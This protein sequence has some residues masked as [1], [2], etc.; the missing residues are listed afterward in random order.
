MSS[1][2]FFFFH[3]FV[4][5]KFHFFLSTKKSNHK[6]KFENA[7]REPNKVVEKL[8]IKGKTDWDKNNKKRKKE[9]LAGKGG[10]DRGGCTMTS[11]EWRPLWG[12]GGP[13]EEYKQTLAGELRL[14]RHGGA[15][16]TSVTMCNNYRPLFLHLYRPAAG[17]G[18]RQG[19]L[20][21]PREQV[22]R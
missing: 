11:W 9:K 12:G 8:R 4:H 16:L 15:R 17:R 18:R 1:F 13:R 14:T 10:A 21:N 3:S 22:H 7:W 19:T 5:P 2:F 20:R 6:F